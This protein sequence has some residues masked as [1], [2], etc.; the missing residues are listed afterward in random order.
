MNR[1]L[2][3]SKIIPGEWYGRKIL[4]K[5][6]DVPFSETYRLN[7]LSSNLLYQG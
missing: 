5:I 2:L 4:K 1:I 3:T 7:Y 6:P